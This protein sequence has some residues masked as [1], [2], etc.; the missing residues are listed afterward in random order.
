MTRTVGANDDSALS[1]RAGSRILN[2]STK[3]SDLTR[4]VSWIHAAAQADELLATIREIARDRA[5]GRS[6][7][8]RSIGNEDGFAAA[9]YFRPLAGRVATLGGIRALPGCAD[10]ACA[11]LNS[12]STELEASGYAQIQ[13]VIKSSEPQSRNLVRMAGY[14]ELTRVHQFWCDLSITG[15]DN[16]WPKPDFDF[17]LIP[18]C[19]RSRAELARLIANTFRETLDCPLVNCLR[20]SHDVLDGFL[21]NRPLDEQL[22]WYVLEV[23]GQDVGCLF[24]SRHSPSVFELAYMGLHP[25][26]RG[27]KLGSRLVQEAKR[28]ASAQGANLLVV[29]VDQSNWPALRIYE[30]HRFY[31]HQ[32]MSVHFRQADML[33]MKAAA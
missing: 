18:A 8:G 11:L 16:G 27:K 29:G 19:R 32:T 31:R 13:A 10:K 5:Q 17:A 24:L 15:I 2:A 7:R 26:M 21:E 3:P 14:L 30:D 4:V 9:C 6:P 25:Q 33:R 23:G 12:L 28:I 22:P 20:Q 1:E